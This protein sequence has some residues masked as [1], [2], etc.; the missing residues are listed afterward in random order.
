MSIQQLIQNGKSIDE[1][2]SAFNA[3][4]HEA[5]LAEVYTLSGADQAKLFEMAKGRVCRLRG[6]FIPDKTPPGTEVIHW[7]FNTLPLHRKF[8]K[9]FMW[10]TKS[11]SPD[12]VFGYNEQTL[13]TFTG[14]G[15]FVAHDGE[16]EKGLTTVVIDY[17]MAPDEKVGPWPTIIPNSARL[18]RWIYNGTKDWM[19]K[20]SDHVTIGRA[21]RADDW[22]PNW[23]VLCREDR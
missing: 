20:V 15:Y 18:S 10:P 4:N 7:G 8:Q 23:F 13:K 14:P 19:W 17:T 1:I 6:E 22:M 12:Q 9:R 11:R 16:I 5:R 2:A 3:M 21:S